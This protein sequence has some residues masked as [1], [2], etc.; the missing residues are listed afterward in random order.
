MATPLR[1]GMKLPD[2]TP[3]RYGMPGLRW[4]GT[5]EEVI[6]ANPQHNQTMTTPYNQ[7][8]Q[9]ITDQMVTDITTA[10]A[11][12]E[13]KLTFCASLT[14]KQRQALLKLGDANNAFAEKSVGYMG[15]NP[16]YISLL[17]PMTEVNKDVKG[18]S[19]IDK[20]FSRLQLALRKV[21]DTRMLMG[22]DIIHAGVAYMHNAGEAAYR[23]Q[24]EAEPIYKDLSDS[25][26]GGSPTKAKK[27][28]KPATP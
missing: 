14:D 5:L 9:D 17:Y 25:Y 7:I 23:G 11:T 8:S 1:W 26:P 12:L 6:A 18:V 19:Q 4:D 27:P 22:S 28:A 13:Q 3:L 20:F 21:E 16:D 24:A 2:G 15:T 10:I